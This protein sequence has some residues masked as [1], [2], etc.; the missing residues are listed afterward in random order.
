MLVKEKMNRAEKE[1]EI[2]HIL[3]EDYNFLNTQLTQEIED[4]NTK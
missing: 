3:S 2:N 1:S 4:M